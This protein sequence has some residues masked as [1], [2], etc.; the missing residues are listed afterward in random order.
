MHDQCARVT[1]RRVHAR[2]ASTDTRARA[3]A[4]D[5]A[6]WEVRASNEE[7]RRANANANAM[8]DA[9]MHDRDDDE[10]GWDGMTM[11]RMNEYI[12]RE[13]AREDD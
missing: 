7:T 2:R 12:E 6:S 11:G 13:G 5:R 8:N 1:P 9:L 3:R 10:D 4:R